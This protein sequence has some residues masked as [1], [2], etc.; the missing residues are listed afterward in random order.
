MDE[1]SAVIQLDECRK[2]EHIQHKHIE[3]IQIY[4]IR[5]NDLTKWTGLAF[6][7]TRTQ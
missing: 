5:I 4:M 1:F 3:L 2:V 6:G 7:E